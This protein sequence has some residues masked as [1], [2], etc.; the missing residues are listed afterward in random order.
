[1]KAEHLQALLEARAGKR[2]CAFVTDLESGAEAIIAQGK[3]EGDL[4]IDDALRAEINAAL[5][6]G[7]SRLVEHEGRQVFIQ[8]LVPKLRLAIIGAGHISQFLTTIAGAAG[9]DVTVIDPR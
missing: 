7:E 6:K 5:S 3:T 9:F 4:E 1:M 2:E 8:A